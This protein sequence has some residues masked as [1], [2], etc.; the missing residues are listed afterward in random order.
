ML[1]DCPSVEKSPSVRARTI[2]V[3][4]MVC[5]QSLVCTLRFSVVNRFTIYLSPA[6]L[7]IIAAANKKSPNK[8]IGITELLQEHYSIYGRSFFSRYDYEEVSSEGA[9]KL[10]TLLNNAIKTSSFVNTTHYSESTK[11]DYKITSVVNFS[12]KD[13]IDGSVSSN[14]GHIV[15]FADGSR[16]VFRLSG[17]GSA[18]ATVRMYIERYVGPEAE[19]EELSKDAA[20]GLKG[21]IE[22]AL[23]ITRLQE[24]LEREDP[25]V[26]TVSSARSSLASHTFTVERCSERSR[27]HVRPRYVLNVPSLQMTH[28]RQRRIPSGFS[29]KLDRLTRL[30]SSL[31]PSQDTRTIIS[32]NTGCLATS[33][34][35]KIPRAPKQRALMWHGHTAIRSLLLYRVLRWIFCAAINRWPA[36]C[37]YWVATTTCP[38]WQTVCPRVARPFLPLAAYGLNATI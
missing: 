24:F 34:R 38:C 17:T 35:R 9:N 36:P 18:G 22:V 20:Q 14:Q 33:C 26:I 8:L 4:R 16:V 30:L 15:A 1:V 6:W 28:I 25:T 10:I 12:Y 11:E 19:E 37:L 27:V 7:N 21:L 5:G 3:R 2:F 23:K 31:N 13:P 32:I 29:E